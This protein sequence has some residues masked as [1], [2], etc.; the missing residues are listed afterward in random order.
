[1]EIR[2]RTIAALEKLASVELVV[3]GGDMLK[4]GVVR[5]MADVAGV[6]KLFRDREV[7]GVLIGCMTF[8]D[9]NSAVSIA[10]AMKHDAALMYKPVMVFPA[11]EPPFKPDGG[12]SSDA[13]CGCLS[14]TSQLVTKGIPFE[15]LPPVFPEEPAFARAVD[16]FARACV[17]VRRFVGARLG[18]VGTHPHNFF[19]CAVN[20][21]EM[22]RRFGQ[23]ILSLDTALLYHQAHSLA[24]DDARVKE[25]VA[26]LRRSCDVSRIAE[27]ILFL[28]AKYETALDQW[29]TD[30]GIDAF[31][32]QCWPVVQPVYGCSA[33]TAMSRLTSR[34]KLAACEV[35]LHGALSMLL[36]YAAALEAVP[37]HFVDWTTN[38]PDDPNKF[39]AW[40]CGNAP[41]E[42]AKD[43]AVALDIQYVMAK[44]G[45]VPPTR[46]TGC[47]W[48]QLKP[49]PVT[50]TRLIEVGGE[51]RLLLT[52]AEVSDEPL[53]THG[54]GAWVRVADLPALYAVLQQSGFVHHCSLIHDD[55][56]DALRM[57]A[58]FLGIQTIGV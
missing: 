44:G 21:R 10:A 16:D 32:V 58:K 43:G 47:S 24:D 22:Y 2:R 8:G 33:C 39:L 57:A 55:H 30:N 9:E 27:S 23:R 50:L 40:H 53:R 51:Y 54:S 41:H 46:A 52:R 38:H 18:R 28:I 26:V 37:P 29:L 15:A 1:M 19:T 31:G 11:K 36:Q 5:G 6:V 48:M 17:A 35:D 49:G 45:V 14:I 56:C 25:I 7:D 3:P 13:F 4:G 12:R 34:G 42:L 20:E